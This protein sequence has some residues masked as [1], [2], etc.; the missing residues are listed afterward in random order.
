MVHWTGFFGAGKLTLIHLGI[1]AAFYLFQHLCSQAADD[2]DV[3]LC[4]KGG[5]SNF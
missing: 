1:K 2:M 3:S 5:D 4:F